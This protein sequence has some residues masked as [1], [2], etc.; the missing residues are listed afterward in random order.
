MWFYITYQPKSALYIRKKKCPK[1][2]HMTSN[3]NFR[4]MPYIYL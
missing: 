2:L 3:T 1:A 4:G